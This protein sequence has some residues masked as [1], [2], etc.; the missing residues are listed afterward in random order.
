MERHHGDSHIFPRH[1]DQA[2][3]L[4][5]S[6]GGLGSGLV[7]FTSPTCRITRLGSHHFR[8]LLLR[9]F[10]FHPPFDRAFLPVWPPTRCSWPSPRSLRTGWGGFALESVVVRDLDLHLPIAAE[11]GLPLF[12]G[13]Q[14]AVDTALV[15]VLHCDGTARR[16]AAHNDGVVVSM[17]ERRKERRHPEL[18]GRRARSRLVVLAVEVGG[19]WSLA[20]QH[21]RA[22]ARCEGLLLRRRAEQAWRLRCGALLCCTQQSV[23]WQTLSWSSQV[24]S[25]PTETPPHMR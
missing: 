5:R 2:K 1:A 21:S 4:L 22:R 8:L 12:G 13:A 10:Q 17:A 11:D 15:S 14:L 7:F 6:Q 24:L 16:G 18:V 9:R 20:T 25:E 19:R 23:L 3:A